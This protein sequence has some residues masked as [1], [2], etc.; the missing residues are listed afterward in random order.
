MRV[1]REAAVLPA[2]ASSRYTGFLGYQ[3]A[4]GM[5]LGVPVDDHAG[6]WQCRPFAAVM[7]PVESL[8]DVR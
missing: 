3:L 8:D 7:I 6:P 5:S 4:L 1:Q 2:A